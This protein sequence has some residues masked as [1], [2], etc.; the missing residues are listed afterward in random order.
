MDIT[1]YIGIT[2]AVTYLLSYFLLQLGKVDGNGISYTLLNMIAACLVLIS[3]TTD[4]NIGSAIIQVSFIALSFY[5]IGRGYMNR[6]A[7]KLAPMEHKLANL[8]FPDLPA[9][10]ALPLIRQGSWMNTTAAQLAKEGQPLDAISVLM[11]GHASVVKS[12]QRVA[13]LGEGQVVGEITWWERL[14]A[15]ADVTIH[16]TAHYFSIPIKTVQE[17]L[18]KNSDVAIAFETGLRK[19]LLRKLA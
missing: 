12:G 13:D 6:R 7:I 1:Q 14:P 9:R 18:V 10:R 19:Q 11:T 17:F 15:N 8:L 3:L 5:A 16:G 2:G 4:F